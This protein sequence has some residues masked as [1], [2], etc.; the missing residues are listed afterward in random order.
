MS[1]NDDLHGVDAKELRIEVERLR[2]ECALYRAA[3]RA[4]NDEL[5]QLRAEVT[6]LR[7][8]RELYVQARSAQS[9]ER[10]RWYQEKSELVRT[11]RQL[12]IDL[13]GARGQIENGTHSSSIMHAHVTSFGYL[14]APP[15]TADFIVDLRE[16]I[17]DPHVSPELRELNGYDFRVVDKVIN[18]FG[19]SLLIDRLV[20]VIEALVQARRHTD[21]AVTVAIGCAGG[22]HR[23]VVIAHE[24]MRHLNNNG[25]KT[26]VRHRDVDF[27]VI[28]RGET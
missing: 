20:K 16:Y 18:T 19:A 8:D 27:P 23:S 28:H 22:R 21:R 6:N 7:E 9:L 5:Y 2:N 26:Q 3:G 4:K 25:W 11:I 13:G 12:E 17:R 14:H 10:E 24:V 1:S 15:P